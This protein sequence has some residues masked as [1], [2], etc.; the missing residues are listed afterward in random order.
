MK[1]IKHIIRSNKQEQLLDA[2][3]VLKRNNY[4]FVETK[5]NNPTAIFVNGM[6][7]CLIKMDYMN[8]EYTGDVKMWC[9]ETDANKFTMYFNINKIELGSVINK[10]IKPRYSKNSH[11]SIAAKIANKLLKDGL[12]IKKNI[13]KVVKIIHKNMI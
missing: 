11:V 5:V 7:F 6:E 1:I 13:N 10:K 9:L 8:T 4:L 3:K 2:V 12:I